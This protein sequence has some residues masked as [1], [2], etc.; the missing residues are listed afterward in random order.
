[1]T[2][3]TIC[4]MLCGLAT[5]IFFQVRAIMKRTQARLELHNSAR[6]LYEAMRRDVMALEQEGA[7]FIESTADAQPGLPP[8][9]PRHTG[10]VRLTFLRGRVDNQDFDNEDDM[11]APRS[12][13]VWTQ[14]RYDQ[15]LTALSTGS[16]TRV[17][18]WNHWDHWVDNANHDF[19]NA[20]W[21]GHTY[22]AMAQPRREAGAAAAATLDDNRFDKAYDGEIGDYKDLMGQ[23]A[24]VARNVAA[25]EL[26]AVLV[27]GKVVHVDVDATKETALDGVFVD[28]RVPA[29][30]ASRQPH[31]QRPVLI[32]VRFDLVD[33]E[34]R[35]KQT[36][37][38]SFQPSAALPPL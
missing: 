9:D 5:S 32:R 3:I 12:D 1:M 36:F 37:S 15:R 30:P 25:F 18:Y 20:P 35:L 8:G 2:S 16:S 26:E 10:E 23:M 31:R 27:S 33:A 13:L 19:G 29:G 24:P 34:T 17:R 22:M 7:C 21:S 6:F 38:F 14:W 4:L 28:G 11:N